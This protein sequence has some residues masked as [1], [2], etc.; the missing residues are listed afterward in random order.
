MEKMALY[1]CTEFG[2]KAAKEWTSGKQTVL[3][4][5]AY[6]QVVLA[7]HAEMVKA[8]RDR[9]NRKLT[10]LRDKRLDLEGKHATNPGNCSL[11]K[12]M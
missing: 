4:E 3:E 10:S 6:S 12:E 11:R 8:T 1:I 9:L 7:R 2:A 5:P